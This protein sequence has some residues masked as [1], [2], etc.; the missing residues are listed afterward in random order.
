MLDGG[1]QYQW[2]TAYARN[3]MTGHRLDWA[4]QPSFFKDYPSAT[5]YPLPLP[6][7]EH[8]SQSSFFTLLK[9]DNH[10]FKPGENGSSSSLNRNDFATLLL[11]TS[12][13]TA[14]ST[15]QQGEIW[16]RS[17]ASAGALYPLEFYFASPR[18][19]D[20]PSGLYHYDLRKPSINHLYRNSDLAGFAAACRNMDSASTDSSLDST[21]CISAIFNR[22]AWKYRERAYRYLLLDCGHALENLA[23]AQQFM[24][25]NSEI[26]LD[27]DDAV[28]NSSLHLDTQREVALAIVRFISPD[29]TTTDQ[30]EIS[31]LQG[32]E[33]EL[34]LLNQNAENEISYP[35]LHEI[36]QSTSAPLKKKPGSGV[37]TSTI[38]SD[39]SEV[40]SWQKIPADFTSSQT[41]LSYSETLS[42]RRSRRNFV[43]NT[44]SLT[45]NNLYQLLDLLFVDISADS[46]LRPE[47]L[48]F[49]NGIEGFTDG[50]YLL[51]FKHKSYALLDKRELRPALAAAALDQRWLTQA[52][53]Q[54]IFFADL[55]LA[56]NEFGPRSYRYLNIAAGRLA[57]RLYLGAT[58]LDLGCCAVGAFY[59][60][61][62]A[63]VCSL[64]ENFDPLYL[65]A[66]GPVSIKQ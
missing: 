23:L 33:A 64:A 17:N 1:H 59:D 35:A 38:F 55:E 22:T 47:I 66:V 4:N 41:S 12:A 42:R 16:Y 32:P 48:F 9:K 25:L 65:V 20:L 43:K 62:L 14:K 34:S 21:F 13:P 57:Q 19:D 8:F 3:Q 49:A 10:S 5:S 40:T 46:R 56:D 28:I 63:G 45:L 58:A 29:T 27:F 2:L 36:H 11:L 61:E 31:D 26:V 51:D 44:G 24:G 18:G 53:L 37:Y 60:R 54:F 50:L 52:S 15:F 39:F 7:L 30:P 6:V